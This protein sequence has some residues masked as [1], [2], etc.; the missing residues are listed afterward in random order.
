MLK[1]ISSRKY[2]DLFSSV[3][4]KN[5]PNN[6]TPTFQA[7][8]GVSHPHILCRSFKSKRTKSVLDKNTNVGHD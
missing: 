6:T 7:V 1:N 5:I 8:S 4:K 2:Y 3:F